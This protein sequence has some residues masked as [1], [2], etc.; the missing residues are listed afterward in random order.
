[1]AKSKPITVIAATWD[2]IA[3]AFDEWASRYEDAPDSFSE[4]FG[5]D[6]GQSCAAYLIELL[7]EGH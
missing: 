3:A 7:E 1:M 4:G 2:Q 6:Y 5:D